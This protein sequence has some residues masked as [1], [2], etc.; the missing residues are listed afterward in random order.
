MTSNP[1]PPPNRDPRPPWRLIAVL[2]AGIAVVG[3]AIALRNS[4]DNAPTSKADL[5]PPGTVMVTD[6]FAGVPEHG[7]TLGNLR[8]PVTMHEFADLKSPVSRVFSLAVLPRLLRRYVRKG[9]LK[10]V[11]EPQHFTGERRSPGDS[12]A[13]ATF[14]LAAA[15]QNRM[16]PFAVLFYLNQE[17][18]GSRYVTDAYLR[19]ISTGVPGL[20]A[21]RA[22]SA[23]GSPA[24]AAQLAAAGALF[25]TRG[26]TDA[27]SF[28]LG[29]S[30]GPQTPLRVSQ[31]KLH[32]F[33]GPIDTLLQH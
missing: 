29:R 33:T 14:A 32:E 5:Q 18:E 10:I 11:F 28:T 4:S 9:T 20:D 26:F 19:D 22:L 12:G 13:A 27:P 2:V 23:R 21:D 8:A 1:A 17:P 15:R 16:W 7:T 31:I 3:V 24:I 6:D 30:D 25:Q